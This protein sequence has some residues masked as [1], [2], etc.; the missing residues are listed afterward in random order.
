MR[1][2]STRRVATLRALIPLV[3]TAL[4][5]LAYVAGHALALAAVLFALA[6]AGALEQ[7][8]RRV[9]VGRVKGLALVPVQRELVHVTRGQQQRL[10]EVVRGAR[11]GA[12]DAVPEQVDAG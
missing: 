10:R 6:A 12:L 7:L 8:V 3:L 9:G 4:A 11:L 1:L 5:R 2:C